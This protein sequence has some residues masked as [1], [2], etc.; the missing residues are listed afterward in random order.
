VAHLDGRFLADFTEAVWA[1]SSGR[2]EDGTDALLLCAKAALI[3]ALDFQ[4]PHVAGDDEED[5]V[6]GVFFPVI[7]RCSRV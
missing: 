7:G 2:T 1:G 3:C 5:V 6:R 4:G